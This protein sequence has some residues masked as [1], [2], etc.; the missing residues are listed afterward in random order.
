MG[1]RREK[2]VTFFLAQYANQTPSPL[3][4]EASAAMAL[5]LDGALAAVTHEETRAVLKK[6]NEYLQQKN[7]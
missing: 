5:P 4:G 1:V 7:A 3:T 6:A 2:H